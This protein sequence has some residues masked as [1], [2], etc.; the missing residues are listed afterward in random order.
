MDRQLLPQPEVFDEPIG[1]GRRRHQNMPALP[2]RLRGGDEQTIC[3]AGGTG[4]FCCLMLVI[5]LM[6]TAS[7]SPN[8]YGVLLNTLSGQ[9]EGDPVRG[10][11]RGRAPWKSYVK[12]PATQ[13]TLIWAK[14]GQDW[15]SNA[16]PI[17]ARAVQNQ[18][19]E[20]LVETDEPHET[21]ELDAAVQVLAKGSEDEQASGQPIYISCAMQFLYNQQ[22][23]KLVYKKFKGHTQAL[24]RY[25][26]IAKNRIVNAAQGYAPEDFWKKRNEI[27]KE[28]LRQMNEELEKFWIK[29]VYFEILKIEFTAQYEENIVKTQVADQKTIVNT[30]E[31]TVTGVLTHINVL[32]AKNNALIAKIKAEAAKKQKEMMATATQGV[33]KLKQNTKA[34]SYARIKT[35]GNFTSDQMKEY[36][37]IKALLS[38]S[39]NG[40]VII[41]V[42]EPGECDANSCK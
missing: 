27:A 1:L 20:S 18:G 10:G 30:Y 12:F 3:I 37:K 33:F 2:S 15:H 31:K 40:A 39:A 26:I 9:L 24:S 19:Q 29:A 41:N 14:P 22:D 13:V 28:M 11:L 21:N 7:L 4:C 42:P 8:E 32:N 17:T 36:I 5:V 38:Q 34:Q 6:T 16:P 35:M 23:L 25:Q